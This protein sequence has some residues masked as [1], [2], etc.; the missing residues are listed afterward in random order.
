MADL[1]LVLAGGRG[2]L[3]DPV[4]AR[5]EA[6]GIGD[7]VH[8]AGY[9]P[10][11]EKTLWYNAAACFCYPSLYEGF[12]LPPLEA[13]ACGIP[14]VTSNVSSLPEVVGDA[15]LTVDPLDSAAL[16]EALH[17]VLGHRGLRTELAA[18]G[19]ERAR[20]FSWVEAARQT[21]DIYQSVGERA[22]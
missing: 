10:E 8:F 1:H 12:G 7:R 13:M 17:R 2:W 15:A 16:C 14:V 9:V 19:I 11:E 5:V 20:R 21:A 6:L 3:A 4:Y 18:R 22:R